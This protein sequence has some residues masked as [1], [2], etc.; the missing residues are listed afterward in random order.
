[1]QQTRSRTMAQS[2][3]Q[4]RLKWIRP[5]K[6]SISLVESF[7]CLDLFSQFSRFLLQTTPFMIEEHWE[8]PKLS[9]SINP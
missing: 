8:L 1:L 9:K 2:K 5:F 3:L 4:K 6:G 7:Q